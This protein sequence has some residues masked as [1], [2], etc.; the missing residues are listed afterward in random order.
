[1]NRVRSQIS[2][3]RL[4][5][6]EA[7]SRSD[8]RNLMRPWITGRSGRKGGSSGCS[9]RLS[10]HSSSFVTTIVPN[11]SPRRR[12][13]CRVILRGK[14]TTHFI[15]VSSRF[16]FHL[17]PFVLPFLGQFFDGIDHLRHKV[18]VR[19]GY[20]RGR[21]RPVTKNQGKDLVTSCVSG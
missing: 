1:M 11:V 13:P 2:A 15:M 6:C 12:A 9:T 17:S 5:A 8:G 7:D 16:L 10:K 19:S 3:S 21:K 4:E 18:I 20:G 14:L